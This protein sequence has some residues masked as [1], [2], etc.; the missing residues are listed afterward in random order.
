VNFRFGRRGTALRAGT[1]TPLPLTQ[2]KARAIFTALVAE[3]T[4]GGYQPLAEG[5]ALPPPVH[6]ARPRGDAAAERAASLLAALGRGHRGDAPLHLV[7]RKVGELGLGEA[8]PLLL[9]L[10]ASDVPEP[11]MNPGA[12]RHFL[13]AA[14]ARCGSTRSVPR[15]E[16]IAN[17]EKAA[18]HLRNV[19]R[20]AVTVIGGQAEREKVAAG[21]PKAFQPE[22]AAELSARVRAAEE[23]L[24]AGHARAHATLF[25]LYLSAPASSDAA[26]PAE[27]LLRRTLLGTVPMMSL[28]G[29][30]LSL[31]RTLNW[32]AEIRRDAEL[33]ALLTR[34]F[35]STHGETT[36]TTQNYFR[37]RAAR[38]LRRL[39]SIGSPDYVKMA[40]ELLLLYRESDA[41]EVMRSPYGTWDE[42]GRYYALNFVLYGN[43]PRYARAGHRG[44]TWRC[45]NG[46]EPGEPPPAVRE[47]S[48]PELWNR[49]PESL[50]RLGVSPAA[51]VV[52]HFAIRALRDQRDY[53]AKV[54]DS[55]VSSAMAHAQ[56]PMRLLAFEV[57]RVRPPN[58]LLARGALASNID[59]ADSWVLD[60]VEKTPGLLSRE[61]ELLALLVTAQGARVRAALPGLAAGLTLDG[62]AARL[63]VSRSIAVLMGLLDEPGQNDRAVSAAAFLL[64]YA[65][66]ALDGLSID[67]VRDLLGHALAGVAA[68]GGE[69]LVRRARTGPLEEGLLEAMLGSKHAE[70]RSL[71]ARIVAE[72]PPAVIKDEPE[73]VIQFALSE[74]AELRQG[75]RALVG[76]VARLYP[77]VG[78]YV[79][80]RLLDALLTAQPQGAPAHVVSLLRNELRSCLPKR[81]V[82]GVFALIGAF[83][84]HAREAGGLLVSLLG[85]DDLELDAIVRLANHEILAIRQ[86]A[87]AL[88]RAA[89]DRFVLTPVALARLCDARWE[90]SRTFAFEFVR[91]FPQAALVPDGVIAICDSVEPLVQ[92]F[93]EKLLLEYFREEHAARYLIRL[94]EHPSTR[95][96]LLVSGL[97]ERYARGNL[98][99]LKE[100][101]PCLMTVLTQVNRGGVA[102][103]RV[104]AFLRTESVA[105][106]EAALLLA[107]L[108]ERQ[109]LTRAVS[110]RAP[111]IATLVDLHE[112]YPE[113][114]VPISSP[115]VQVRTRSSR[116]V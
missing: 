34:R 43:S 45:Q 103:Q 22:A 67:V 82:K 4:R 61:I 13:I 109:S 102:K 31:A 17:D 42:F 81:D 77:D 89:R 106:A 51:G 65:G 91:S 49:A 35:E 38:T 54:D 93:G 7:V 101:M 114:T 32:A 112:R 72:T 92:A 70:V 79:A 14:L 19:S 3:K 104:L 75:T 80:S 63:V 20:L 16:A 39:G 60:W 76:E 85:P 52:I 11:G 107:P 29:Q 26:T 30:E 78:Q 68:L 1:K 53:L 10:L 58:L 56:R 23:L 18:R 59:E 74:N 111:L 110:H 47:E 105:N 71:G 88:A 113:V 25:D 5:D 99:L 40:T 86:G 12:F 44:A 62:E 83:S 33:F 9:E 2:E 73:L 50:W 55:A 8:E 98:V 36:E 69:L 90:D 15:L 100:L 87:W 64:R 21:L 48:H 57:A 116:G 6:R 108:L 37:R 97:L 95:V 84:P 94:S 46:Y 66:A 41:D 27:L 28:D 24:T 96:Q 115:P